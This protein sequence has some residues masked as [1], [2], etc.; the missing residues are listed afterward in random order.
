M[1]NYKELK[2][3]NLGNQLLNLSN[4]ENISS[5][6]EHIMK[7][8]LLQE[9]NQKSKILVQLKNNQL[10]EVEASTLMNVYHEILSCKNSLLMALTNLETETI[11]K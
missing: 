8:V 11:K 7:Q 5:D 6:I 1:H 3:K 4:K 9:E 2:I 10:N